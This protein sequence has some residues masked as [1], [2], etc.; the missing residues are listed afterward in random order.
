MNALDLPVSRCRAI[1]LEDSNAGYRDGSPVEFAGGSQILDR[2]TRRR[3]VDVGTRS[4]RNC[5]MSCRSRLPV[6]EDLSAD[7]YRQRYFGAAARS[8][9]GY[10]FYRTVR[11]RRQ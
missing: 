3:A 2:V 10:L 9:S 7:E 11:T 6:I 4:E 5:W 1:E 8:M